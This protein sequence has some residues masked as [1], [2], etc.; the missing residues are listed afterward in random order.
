M[1][2]EELR[3][4][5]VVLISV[6][7]IEAIQEV[8]ATLALERLLDSVLEYG[9]R[10]DWLFTYD[11]Y[12]SPLT[13]RHWAGQAVAALDIAESIQFMIDHLEKGDD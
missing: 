8:A 10:F 5:G 11:T 6:E 1:M 7:A 9:Q 12:F 2:I 3:Q 4:E 13:H